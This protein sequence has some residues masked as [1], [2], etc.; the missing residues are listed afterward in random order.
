M[1]MKGYTPIHGRKL[2]KQLRQVAIALGFSALLFPTACTVVQAQVNLDH[3]TFSINGKNVQLIC[4]EMHYPRIPREYW[5]DRMRRARAMGLN[6]LS[7]YV[8]WNFHE[9]TPGVFDFSGQADI[10]AFVRTAQEEGLYVILRPG[11][12][13]CAEWDFGGYPAWLLKEKGMN[14]RS[15]DPRF[16]A[17][18]RRY[19]QELG[20]QLAPFSANKGGNLIM[21]QVEN[22]YGSY[23]ADK[24]YLA[25]LR[26]MIREAGFDVPLLTCDGGGQVEAGHVEGALP[27]L[28]G[29]FGED[30]FRI[31]D[32]YRP[33][34][35]YFVAE[36]YPAWFD[37]WGKRHSSVAWQRPAAQLDWMLEHG[38]SVSMY[39][40]HGGTNFWYTNGANTNGGFEPQPTSYDYDA[41]LGEWGN[42]S[43]KYYAFRDV[44]QKHLPAGTALPDVPADN[45]TTT[46][47]TVELRESAPLSAAFHQTVTS[48]EVLSMEDVGMD[49]GYIYYQTT[50]HQG[51]RQKLVLQDLRDYAVVL[52]NGQPVAS[53]DRRY[54]QNS[55]T[56]EVKKVPATLELLVENTGR[57]NYGPDIPFNR[58]GITG[59]VMWGDEKLKGWSVTPLPLYKENVSALPFGDSLN[60]VPAF[61]RATF[62]VDTVGDCFVDM[63]RWGKGAVWVNGRSLGRFWNIG[64][65]QTLYLPAPW[66]KEGENEIIVFEMEDTGNRS[67][68]GLDRPVLNSLGQD[69][70]FREGP[71]RPNRGTPVL[72]E[73]DRVLEATLQ[74]TN[75]WQTLELPNPVSLRHLC[76][77][78]LSSYTD[79]GQSCLSE[80]ELTDEQGRAIDKSAWEVVYVSSERTE[81]NM[82]VA[83]NLIDGDVSSF[84]HTD[85]KTEATPP[86]RII[87]DLQEIYQVSSLRLKV[88]KGSFLSGKVKDIRVYARPQFFLFR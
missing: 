45:P 54:N 82:G 26:D 60:G 59:Q 32:K 29:V 56:L 23:A 27:T 72:D 66:L 70:N 18:C 4:G 81:K 20:K 84:W 68:E 62:R 58:K 61:H 34:G 49:F 3:G 22:E 37:V 36:F 53:L 39:M 63:S 5:R 71:R 46:F 35:P 77:E 78:T 87:I 65:Q 24:E 1:N 40:F 51:G 64:P 74:E 10:A 80:L 76:I 15:N 13:V 14:Y 83:E 38:V 75:D 7:A 47:A 19:L 31:V 16:L 6:T 67:V 69:K 33:G 25:A 17:Y 79:D 9:R 2:R 50:L 28:N 21:V 43:P 44:I 73:G 55:V 48:D 30:I 12:Y 86:H 11:P 42:C 88:R 8:F 41:P 52:L 85:A 57:V